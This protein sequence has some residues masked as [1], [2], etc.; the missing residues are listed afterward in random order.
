M[1]Y[2]HY[3]PS[4]KYISQYNT[5]NFCNN[6]SD[7]GLKSNLICIKAGNNSWFN[8]NQTKFF[9]YDDSNNNENYNQLNLNEV[10]ELIDNNYCGC[11]NRRYGF[12]CNKISS[13]KYFDLVI[14][15]PFIIIYF[16][17]FFS[18]FYYLIVYY[19]KY[20]SNKNKNKKKIFMNNIVV[21]SILLLIAFIV[22][23]ASLS[24][25]LNIYMFDNQFNLDE[26]GV[27]YY[28]AYDYNAFM[29]SA[30][31]L[32]T[33]IA[34]YNMFKG[35]LDVVM[36]SPILRK[37]NAKKILCFSYSNWLIFISITQ[38]F[39]VFVMSVLILLK[40]YQLAFISGVPFVLFTIIICIYS[41]SKINNTL[42]EVANLNNSNKAT[43]TH[44]ST[45]E[46]KREKH[47][48]SSGNSVRKSS[49]KSNNVGAKNELI[50]IL[51]SI[52][53]TSTLVLISYSFCLA[54]CVL[55]YL[56]SSFPVFPQTDQTWPEEFIDIWN[57][58]LKVGFC[59]GLGGALITLYFYLRE[60][61]K[62]LCFKTKVTRQVSVQTD[63]QK[64]DNV[65]TS[66][67]S[68]EAAKSS[69]NSS[70]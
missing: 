35:W 12:D 9:K 31:V 56:Y 32:T 34:L 66:L 67:S 42:L 24:I 18:L 27:K 23:A 55:I 28:A 3:I 19:N 44:A 1:K 54:G 8:Y 26:N 70:T 5:N 68:I 16:I 59:F 47:L 6:D 38:L 4:N 25:A 2:N 13:L 53:K 48:S 46:T 64:L 14:Y 41:S 21:T 45:P 33:T 20:K 69:V 10:N 50:V 58:G 17:L 29:N 30:G 36:N 7:C 22:N 43:V 57:I 51:N 15:L 39:F 37:T 49:R 11:Y 61:L 65:K 60:K 40:Q 63:N 62:N 52:K